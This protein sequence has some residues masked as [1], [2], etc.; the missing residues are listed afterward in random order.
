MTPVLYAGSH[1]P[2]SLLGHLVQLLSAQAQIVTLIRSE[3]LLEDVLV[4]GR[5]LL[6]LRA[7]DKPL[8]L[9]VGKKQ[10]STSNKSVDSGIS[11]H[12]YCPSSRQMGR[13]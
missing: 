1:L 9:T 2:E 4:V 7:V 8:D 10:S 3:H 5:A 13:F 6:S 11:V 12:I